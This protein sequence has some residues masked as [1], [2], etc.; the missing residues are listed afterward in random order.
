MRFK[1]RNSATLS[2]DDE[3]GSHAKSKPPSPPAPPVAS[4]LTKPFQSDWGPVV[5][6]GR[7]I[8]GYLPSFLGG[9]GFARCFI[10]AFV[11]RA[12]VY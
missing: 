1:T 7:L 3:N 6:G 8:G 12:L 11:H 2:S 9:I 10:G 5:G 4:G